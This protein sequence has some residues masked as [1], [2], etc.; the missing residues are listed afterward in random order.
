MNLSPYELA[1]WPRMTLEAAIRRRV[2]TAYLGD[3]VVLAR[4]LGRHKM[5]LRSAD[6]GFACNVMLDGY[7]E[8]WLTQFLAQR[9][10]PGMTVIDVGANFGY[11]TLLMG[12]AVGA[13][14]RVLAVEPNPE[15]AALLQQTVNL[16]GHWP[17]TRL[18]S[19]A[20]GASAGR[21]WLYSPD[22]EPKNASLVV[23]PDLPGGKTVE[24]ATVTLDELALDYPKIDL[25]KIDAEG[26]EQG[27]VAGMQR[28]IARDRPLIVLEFNAVRYAEP[29]AFLDGLLAHYGAA[30]ELQPAGD[31]VPL[32]RASVLD[33]TNCE[34]RL[35]VFE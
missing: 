24:V 7:W 9:L 18:V 2:Q 5:F 3:G 29:A 28:L 33:Q 4:V 35:L 34:D 27:I 10:K 13:A 17:Q 16:A 31:I 15:A 12:E 6:R 19:Q 25:V 1:T 26:G 14:G 22:G 21:A 23:Q 8:I 30:V 20:L 32:D 11:Y